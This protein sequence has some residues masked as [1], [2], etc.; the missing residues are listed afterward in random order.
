VLVVMGVAALAAAQGSQGRRT[1]TGTVTD[2]ECSHADHSLMQMGATDAECAIA[3]V[4]A[5]GASLV[6]YDGKTVYALSDQAAAQK[7]AGRKVTV[8]GT[9]DAD[10]RTIR[11]DSI[12]AT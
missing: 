3:C 4:D 12:A 11:V 2:S 7:F 9:L 10:G 6:L 8:A 5:H 1:F